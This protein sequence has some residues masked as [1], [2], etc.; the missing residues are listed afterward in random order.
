VW[1]AVAAGV[2]LLAIAVAAIVLVTQAGD[3]PPTVR[4]L[5]VAQEDTTATFSW[6]DPGLA[7]GDAYLVTVD[8]DAWP[9]QREAAVAVDVSDGDRVCVSVRVMRDGRAGAAS[10]E[11]C[12][13]PERSV[14]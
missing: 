12:M 6:D 4:E 8:G 10:P 9:A 5:R 14:G 13:T 1:A 3:V 2:A 7:E 11:S